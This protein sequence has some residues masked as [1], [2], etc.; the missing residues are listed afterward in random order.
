MKEAPAE[1]VDWRIE[2]EYP[3]R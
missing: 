3:A 2:P 1:R